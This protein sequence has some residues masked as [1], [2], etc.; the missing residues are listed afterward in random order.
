MSEGPK[1]SAMARRAVRSLSWGILAGGGIAVGLA[2]GSSMS[3]TPVDGTMLTQLGL[4]AGAA[5]AI[6]GFVLPVKPR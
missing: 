6:V 4:G 1:Q 5:G 2:A 3:S